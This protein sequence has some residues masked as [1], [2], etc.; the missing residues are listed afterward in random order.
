MCHLVRNGIVIRMSRDK[1]WEAAIADL[2]VCI[3]VRPEELEKTT[4]QKEI[5]KL[6]TFH[7]QT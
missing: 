3:R 2:D 7:M 6:Y 5:R 1:K 4:E